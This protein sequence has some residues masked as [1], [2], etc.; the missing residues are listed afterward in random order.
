[1]EFIQKIL[2]F[3]S[4]EQVIFRVGNFVFLYY[5]LIVA[6]AMFF[7]YLI[8]T[9]LLQMFQVPLSGIFLWIIV[10]IPTIAIGSRAFPLL[11]NFRKFLQNPKKVFRD[12]WFSYLGGF[13]GLF[14]GW[15]IIGF[16]LNFWKYTL[17]ISDALMLF[18]P[19]S[20]ILGRFACVNY[21]CCTGKIKDRKIGLYFSYKGPMA[22]AVKQFG[23]KDIRVCPVHLYEMV[24]NLILTIILL[25]IFLFVDTFGWIS[26]TYMLG[27]GLIRLV[28]EPYRGSKKIL[29]GRYSLYQIWLTVTFVLFGIGYY[30][31][32]G[33]SKVPVFVDFKLEYIWNSLSFIPL[34]LAM[35]VLAFFMFGTRR[36]VSE[37]LPWWK[38]ESW[39]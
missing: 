16:Y 13:Y 10:T 6:I 21:G 32:A 18:L 24:L 23:L 15:M 19:L 3:V 9:L 35:C 12:K 1:M 29:W 5:G 26:G 20:H 22:R 38:K 36:I 17:N 2:N 31:L 25:L 39:K 37:V 34:I 7:S 30:I 4:K 27:Y 33:I 11:L 28:L 14:L 8:S